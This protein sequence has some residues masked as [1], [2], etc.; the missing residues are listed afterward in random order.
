MKQISI[1]LLFVGTAIVAAFFSGWASH[2]IATS[3]PTA[4]TFTPD[5]AIAQF[6][7]PLGSVSCDSKTFRTELE[8]LIESKQFVLAMHLLDSVRIDQQVAQD[9]EGCYYSI[10]GNVIQNPG[11]KTAYDQN[12]DYVMPGTGCCIDS[13]LWVDRAWRFAENYNSYRDE[14]AE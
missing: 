3:K 1:K 11:T 4:I 12:R 10:A 8:S 2:Q 5:P 6:D 13:F 9:G 7:A 14:I